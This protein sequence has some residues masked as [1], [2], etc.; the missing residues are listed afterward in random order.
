MNDFVW[1]RN[2]AKNLNLVLYTDICLEE[3]RKAEHSNEAENGTFRAKINVCIE[4]VRKSAGGRLL[5]WSRSGSDILSNVKR[6]QGTVGG[7]LWPLS[8]EVTE[9]PNIIDRII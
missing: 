5:P 1:G 4:D 8:V 3:K 7:V 9:W 6:Y 2:M